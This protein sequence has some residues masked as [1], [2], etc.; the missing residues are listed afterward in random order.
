VSQIAPKCLRLK[1]G[2]CVLVRNP[3]GSDALK[4]AD[5]MRAVAREGNYTLTEVD[6]VDWTDQSKRQDIKEHIDRP[7]YLSIVAEVAGN[8]VG[9]LEFENGHRRRTMHSGTLAIFVRK[10]WREKGIGTFLLKTLLDWATHNPLIVK[11]G[12]SVISTNTRAIKL[13]KKLGFEIEGTCTREIRISNDYYD[14]I[15]MYKFVK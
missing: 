15:L 3:L 9:F 6:E 2:E 1:S 11:V 7:G 12:L 10:G 8:V 4:L 14:K 5:I 13:Y